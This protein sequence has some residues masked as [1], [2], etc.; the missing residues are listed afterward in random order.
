VNQ[1]KKPEVKIAKNKNFTLLKEYLAFCFFKLLHYIV[2]QNKKPKVKIAK[3]KIFTLFKGCLP[4]CFLKLIRY[5]KSNVNNLRPNPGA[6][7]QTPQ[8]TSPLT[9]S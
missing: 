3:T 9:P 7:P 6:L 1:N 5:K 2:N 4:F 8:G